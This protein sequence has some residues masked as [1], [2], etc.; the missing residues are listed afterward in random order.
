MTIYSDD[1]LLNLSVHFYC[2]QK[3]FDEAGLARGSKEADKRE[4]LIAA[5]V[6]R[7]GRGLQIMYEKNNPEEASA[8]PAEE[9]DNVYILPT[10]RNS[11]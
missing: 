6:D 5:A 7:V 11:A 4:A 3:L 9:K 1:D 10:W 8:T 2:A